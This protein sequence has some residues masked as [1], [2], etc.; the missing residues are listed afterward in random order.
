MKKIRQA[1]MAVFLSLM[2]PW[3]HSVRA[4]EESILGI[5]DQGLADIR[6]CG[7]NYYP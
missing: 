3:H 5:E 6:H 7:T 1:L 2:I 4:E